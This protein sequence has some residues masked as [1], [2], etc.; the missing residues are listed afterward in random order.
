MTDGVLTRSRE[1]AGLAGV[2]KPIARGEKQQPCSGSRDSELTADNHII[3][4]SS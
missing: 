1:G 2:Q 4:L 3:C